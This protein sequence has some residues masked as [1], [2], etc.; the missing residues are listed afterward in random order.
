MINGV[1][2]QSFGYGNVPCARCY[3]ETRSAVMMIPAKRSCPAGWTQE[4]EGLKHL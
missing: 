2:Y 3:T 1:E 4:Y